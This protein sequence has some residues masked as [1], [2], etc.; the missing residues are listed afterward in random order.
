MKPDF[1]TLAL[2]CLACFCVFSVGFILG[3]FTILAAT[4]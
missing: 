3:I 2:M 1:E 4:S